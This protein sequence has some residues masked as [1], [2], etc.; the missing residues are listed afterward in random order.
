MRIPGLR[1]P[2]AAL[3]ATEARTGRAA[4]SEEIPDLAGRTVLVVD[5]SPANRTLMERILGAFGCTVI[6]AGSGEEALAAAE[7]SACDL[8]FMDIQLPGMNGIEAMR[9][10]RQKGMRGP[11]VALTAFAMK[12]D[13]E[14]F[15]AEGFDGFIAK[16][17]RISEIVSFLEGV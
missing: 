8:V 3:P 5:D 11:F 4:G 16:P 17:V 2:A 7:G 9:R 14:R 1:Q 10:L 13:P 15:L 6:S 12:G